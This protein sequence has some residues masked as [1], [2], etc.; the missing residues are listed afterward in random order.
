[1]LDVQQRSDVIIGTGVCQ[2]IAIKNASNNLTP[3]SKSIDCIL[4]I[5]CR[6]RATPFEAEHLN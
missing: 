5:S 4:Q 1:M 3:P 6:L 2:T